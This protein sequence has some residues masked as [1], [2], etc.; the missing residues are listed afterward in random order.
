MDGATLNLL[1]ELALGRRAELRNA[2]HPSIAHFGPHHRDSLR[3]RAELQTAA[4]AIAYLDR[5]HIQ[6]AA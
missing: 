2:L 5:L 1:R 3:L 4:A 6:E